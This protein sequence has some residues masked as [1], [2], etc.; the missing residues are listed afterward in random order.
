MPASKQDRVHGKAEPDGVKT[1]ALT[2][3]QAKFVEVYDGNGTKAC[4]LAGYK[5][6]D[7]VMAQ[8]ARDNLSNPQIREAIRAREKAEVRPLVATR[9]QRQAFWTS[10]MGDVDEVMFARL[11]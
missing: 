3:K 9:Q 2:V 10:V 6:S 1:R 5:G 11:K 4:R 8:Q 7:N